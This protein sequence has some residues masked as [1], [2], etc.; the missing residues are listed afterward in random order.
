MVRHAE[1]VTGRHVDEPALIH[2]VKVTVGR[3][4][5]KLSDHDRHHH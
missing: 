3:G 4:R 5:V 1:R 2:M